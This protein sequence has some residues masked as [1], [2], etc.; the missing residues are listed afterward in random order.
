VYSIT[1][2]PVDGVAVL[3][4]SLLILEAGLVMLE[5]HGDP[6]NPLETES[7]GSNGSVAS[8]LSVNVVEVY[9]SLIGR[10]TF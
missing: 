4:A 9:K 1:N 3:T 2:D 6:R 10:D 7:E 8:D 5:A